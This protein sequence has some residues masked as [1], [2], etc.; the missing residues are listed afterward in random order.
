MKRKKKRIN[1]YLKSN[2]PKV[3]PDLEEKLIISKLKKIQII[4]IILKKALTFNKIK[5]FF[6]Q[7]F[8]SIL[9]II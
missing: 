3:K 4:E 9:N 8:L 5:N 1:I 7:N 2:V 6:L